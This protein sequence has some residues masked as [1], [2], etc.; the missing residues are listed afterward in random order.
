MFV[1]HKILNKTKNSFPNSKIKIFWKRIFCHQLIYIKLFIDYFS[2][3]IIRFKFKLSKTKYLLEYIWQKYIIPNKCILANI[4]FNSNFVILIIYKLYMIKRR[5]I[6]EKI[7]QKLVLI[8]KFFGKFKF[9]LF[10][11]YCQLFYTRLFLLFGEFFFFF[12]ITYNESTAINQCMNEQF[13]LYVQIPPVN[14][15]SLTNA[16]CEPNYGSMNEQF[17]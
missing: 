3:F 14:T 11:K 9:I 15:T 4:L 2:I 1:K 13:K 8:W 10:R 5:S 16:L 17:S 12:K 6:Q 7:Q